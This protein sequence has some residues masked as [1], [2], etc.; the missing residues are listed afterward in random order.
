MAQFVS[1]D[2]R[3][4]SLTACHI[5]RRR[6]WDIPVVVLN[7]KVDHEAKIA[8][9]RTYVEARDMALRFECAG[10]TWR[11]VPRHPSPARGH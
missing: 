5:A 7:Q 6:Q 10:R 3:E 8:V 9:G 4:P 11:S 2:R 1:T